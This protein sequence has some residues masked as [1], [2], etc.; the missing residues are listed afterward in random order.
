TGFGILTGRVGILSGGVLSLAGGNEC[1]CRNGGC[2]ECL[3]TQL[4][5]LGLIGGCGFR[6]CLGLLCDTTGFLRLALGISLFGGLLLGLFLGLLGGLGAGL[7][8]CL[9]P[10]SGLGLRRCGCIGCIGCLRGEFG[11]GL[12]LLGL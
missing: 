3:I 1:G 11:D 5:G 8:R 12:G 9:D 7:R 4:L 2:G 6:G 10:G